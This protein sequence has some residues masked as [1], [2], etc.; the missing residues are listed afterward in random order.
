MKAY[1]LLSYLFEHLEPGSVVVVTTNKENIPIMLTKE[2]EYT[3][4]AYVCRSEEV[5]R[6]HE[7]FDKPTLHRA[8]LDLLNQ[9]A[10]FL[11]FQVDELNIANTAS[12]PECIPKKEPKKVER[13]E[14]KK[15]TEDVKSLIEAM[16]TLP[17]EYD[18]VPL[19]TKDGKLVSLVL[20]NQSLVTIDKI[21]KVPSH[22]SN[23]SITPIKADFET[24]NYVLSTIKFDLQ[25]GN[26]L[27]SLDNLTFFTALFIDNGDI[28]EGEFLGRKIPKRSGKFFTTTSKGTLHPL[29]LEFLDYNK[30]K[31]GGLYV[32]Y[33]IHDG[34]NFVRLGG[35]DLLETHEEGKF[36][37][38]AYIFSSFLVGSRDF[39]VDYQTYDKLLGNFV[40]S[41]LSKGIGG[42]YVKDVLELENL[43]YDI[44]YVKNVNGNNISIVDPISF[45]YYKSRGEEVNLCTDCELKDKVELWNKIIKIWFKEFIL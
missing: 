15:R 44:L 3:I 39:V 19:I 10:D 43:L 23:G 40:N 11:N 41:V 5:K 28:G 29:P 38:N 35:F 27:S 1:D 4:S 33:F 25:K 34:Q 18:I 13:G 16:K 21:V 6:L 17:Q 42:K 9:L 22:L 30:N 12:F 7:V 31:K 8:V 20:Q 26:P 32:G 2:D 45:W 36:T 14:K 24:L 37:I